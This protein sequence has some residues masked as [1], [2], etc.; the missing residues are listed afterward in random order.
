MYVNTFHYVPEDV[1][2]E[3]C[4]EFVRKLG[5]TALRCP[6]LA[7]RMEAGT[8]GYA[9]A[10]AEL[11]PLHPRLTPRLLR[12]SETFPGSLWQD[13]EHKRR[14][15]YLRALHGFR[16]KRDTPVFLA[17]LYLLTSG[18]DL[19]DRTFNC[20]CRDGIDFRYA[21]RRGISQHN[22]TLL[23]AAKSLYCVTDEVTKGDLADPQIIPDEAF[24]LIIN[25]LLI[26]R[27]GSDA[28]RIS[29]R[30]SQRPAQKRHKTRHPDGSFI[31]SE[32]L[33]GR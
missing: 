25:S 1:A 6:C 5:C 21:R 24:R 31:P 20:F 28:L 11:F 10:V 19:G 7:E 18:K 8:V 23:M 14:F 15:T 27:F 3:L 30:Q 16:R 12:L 2:C 17:V 26:A 29:T 9:E 32:P 22:Y 33:I 4:T 13:S